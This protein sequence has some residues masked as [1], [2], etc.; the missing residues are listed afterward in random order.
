MASQSDDESIAKLAPKRKAF[1]VALGAL[2]QATAELDRIES[3]PR[4]R[5]SVA[6]LAQTLRSTQRALGVSPENGERESTNQ[7]SLDARFETGR[8]SFLR[9]R[10][11]LIQD[12]QFQGQYA[13]IAKDNVID[14]D[15]DEVKLAERV[16]KSLP[17]I[18]IFIGCVTDSEDEV[19][20][21]SP[22]FD[23]L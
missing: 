2:R 12:P 5:S 6:R 1:L 22:E 15:S 23:D 10:P 9:V 8:S 7:G 3:E 19:V 11:I 13:A 14:A 4:W 20:L 17:S 16:A 18:P 21:S